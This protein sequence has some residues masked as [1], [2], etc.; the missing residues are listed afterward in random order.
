MILRYSS[1][2]PYNLYVR[3]NINIVSIPYKSKIYILFYIYF[4]KIKPI[5]LDVKNIV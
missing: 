5:I 2:G 4:I 3:D 1:Y